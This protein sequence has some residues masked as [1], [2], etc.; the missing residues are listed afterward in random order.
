MFA[1]VF[2]LN[3]E[4][5]LSDMA[6]NRHGLLLITK[7]GVGYEGTHHCKKD[8][9]KSKYTLESVSEVIA[10]LNIASSMPSSKFLWS[11]TNFSMKCR[12]SFN[13]SHFKVELLCFEE[14]ASGKFHWKI[15]AC[16]VGWQA[17]IK[18]FEN[19]AKLIFH[20]NF[21]VKQSFCH[22]DQGIW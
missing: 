16:T 15:H 2:N 5:L 7:D 13:D 14:I 20:Q 4:L 22:F 6:A 17:D 18:N 21:A 1:C 9:R 19:L 11:C 12:W 10:H 3:R 8:K